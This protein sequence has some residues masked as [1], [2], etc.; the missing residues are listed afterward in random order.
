[1]IIMKNLDLIIFIKEIVTIHF[2]KDYCLYLTEVL[3]T[4]SLNGQSPLYI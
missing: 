3:N 1:M 4:I 2:T